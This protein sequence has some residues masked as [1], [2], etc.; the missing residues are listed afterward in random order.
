MHCHK[1]NH[2]MNGNV[3]P[4]GTVDAIVYKEVMDTDIFKQLMSHAGYEA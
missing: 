2:A 3:Y 1:V 4:G